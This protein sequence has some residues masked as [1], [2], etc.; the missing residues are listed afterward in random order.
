MT[1]LFP[2]KAV[3]SRDRNHAD[4][5]IQ[6]CS[7]AVCTVTKFFQFMVCL[8]GAV[9]T[10]F[11]LKAVPSQCRNIAVYCTLKAVPIVL[12]CDNT[13]KKI[14]TRYSDST[15][16]TQSILTHVVLTGNFDN[17]VPIPFGTMAT[18][19]TL[20][21]FTTRRSTVT[22]LFIRKQSFSYAG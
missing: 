4:V 17:A 10:L 19:F 6:N 5:F 16:H 20:K 9:T 18:L 21:T 11:P 8:R 2:F 3:P 13:V 12:Y 1:A 22:T 15:V 14:L 7:H